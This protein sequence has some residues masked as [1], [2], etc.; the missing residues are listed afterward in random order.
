MA[1]T[2]DDGA[3]ISGPNVVTNPNNPVTNMLANRPR[4]TWRG[5]TW[6]APVGVESQ[7][8]Q[9]PARVDAIQTLGG[10]QVDHWGP[11]LPTLQIS[12][13][14]GWGGNYGLRGKQSYEALRKLITDYHL[15][16]AE[17]PNPTHEALIY[18]NPLDRITMH[19]VCN[20]Q[21]LVL[22]RS[23][24]EPNLYRWELSM[25]VVRDQMVAQLPHSIV[26]PFLRDGF[27][28][29]SAALPPAAD[30]ADD[31]DHIGTGGR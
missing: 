9:Y 14:T 5:Y 24:S 30:V 22:R 16:C 15:A 27:G 25:I 23:R 7:T 28:G 4:L 13:T 12:A 29:A 8:V 6:I 20:P 31:A 10:A 3:G 19:V 18:E 11:G 2:D 21:G 26:K 17:S 1:V